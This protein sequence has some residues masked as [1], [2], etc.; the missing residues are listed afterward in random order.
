MSRLRIKMILN[1]GGE[2]V[3]LAQLT[4]IADETE[5]FLRYLAEEVGVRAQRGEWLARNFQDGSCVF[6]IE[7]EV[8][9]TDDQAREFNNRIEYINKLKSERR[10]LNGE[11]RHRTLFQFTRI[12]KA[13]GPHEKVTLGLLSTRYR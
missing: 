4:D 13:L 11:V 6:D 7:R 3:P 10:S 12:A 9:S 1:E 8:L 5:K 2:G